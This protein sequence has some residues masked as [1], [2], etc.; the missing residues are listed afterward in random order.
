MLNH[1]HW[2]DFQTTQKVLGSVG[3]LTKSNFHSAQFCFGVLWR[4]SWWKFS[5]DV[6][7]VL[8]SLGISMLPDNFR[9]IFLKVERN[10]TFAQKIWSGTNHDAQKIPEKFFLRMLEKKYGSN[11]CPIFWALWKTP[12]D[13]RNC[14]QGARIF[15]ADWETLVKLPKRFANISHD[16]WCSL[17]RLRACCQ[18]QH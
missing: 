17:T 18:D 14:F 3:K 1:S 9:Q 11:F 10:F 2:K 7:K 4:N 13:L 8:G 15:L 16:S 6:W 12:L 5:Q